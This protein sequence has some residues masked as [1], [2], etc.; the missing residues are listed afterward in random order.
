MSPR[1]S[2]RSPLSSLKSPCNSRRSPRISLLSCCSSFKSL[3]I[4]PS[5]AKV[6]APTN[7][8]DDAI[9][10]A[11]SIPDNLSMILSVLHFLAIP[12]I[13]QVR[14]DPTQ[15]VYPDSFEGLAEH[16]F[17]VSFGCLYL[18]RSLR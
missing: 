12:A 16:L 9:M 11:P 10:P 3:L 1:S 7:N 6:E 18:K 8:N 15:K 4:S 5:A 13:F 17:S 14:R 2:L